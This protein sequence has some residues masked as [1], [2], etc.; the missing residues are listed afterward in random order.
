MNFWNEKRDFPDQAQPILDK[1][2]VKP[3]RFILGVDLDGPVQA[4]D[5]L[6]IL[7]EGRQGVPLVAPGRSVIGLDV[8]GVFVALQGI[9][10]LSELLAAGPAVVPGVGIGRF[11]LQDAIVVLYR[12]HMVPEAGKAERLIVEL[13]GLQF[14]GRLDDHLLTACFGQQGLQVDAKV[15]ERLI[16]RPLL[17]F[18]AP[19]DDGK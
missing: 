7:P 10:D 2:L 6:S 3:G 11:K 5:G 12:L 18:Q 9:L 15:A 1:C 4:D 14:P 17:F 19:F 13:P 16:P 8:E